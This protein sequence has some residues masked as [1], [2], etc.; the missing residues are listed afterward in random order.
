MATLTYN[1][2]TVEVADDKAERL[3]SRGFEKAPSSEPAP[4]PEDKPKRGPGR[5]RKPS[6]SE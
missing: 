5:P 1:G 2:V 3:T 4:S 6:E